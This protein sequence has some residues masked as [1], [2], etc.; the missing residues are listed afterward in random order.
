MIQANFRKLANKNQMGLL[1]EGLLFRRS[2]RAVWG[3]LQPEQSGYMSSTD[4]PIIIAHETIADRTGRG[5]PTAQLLGDLVQA[6]PRTWREALL[7]TH[8]ECLRREAIP[9]VSI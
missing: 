9:E 7:E 5:L 6:F 8:V 1:Q 4:D 2:R 3:S